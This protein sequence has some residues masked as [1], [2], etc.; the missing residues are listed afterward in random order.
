MDR[1]EV[2]KR[3][4]QVFELA[5]RQLKHLVTEYPDT[6]PSFTTHGKWTHQKEGW[7]NWCEGFLG[8]QLWLVYLYGGDPWF[9]Q[10]AEHYCRLVEPRQYD[11]TV[12]DLG[13]I[14][15]PTWKRWYDL[16]GDE[17]LNQVVIQAGQTLA[18]RF[19]EAGGYICSFE[20][21]HSTYIDI[22]SNIGLVFYAAQQT[23]DE[24]LWRIA[25][26]HCLTTR[27]YLVRGDGST[28]H[29]GIFD[30]QSGCFLRQQTRQGWRDDSSWVRGQCW[31]I[32]GFSEAFGYTQDMI[33]LDTAERLAEFYIHRTPEW[34]IP[35]NDWEEPAQ[36]FPCESSAAAIAAF[37]MWRLAKQTADAQRGEFYRRYALRIIDTLT[38][39]HFLAVVRPD[40]EGILMHGIY[41]LPQNTG[42]DESM[43]WGDYFLL[44]SLNSI[45]QEETG[46]PEPAKAY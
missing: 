8:G 44:E 37:G 30:P 11:T 20:G 45:A 13:F 39:S 29:E 12:H 19:Q 42:V 17:K 31:A 34:G 6:F 24:N 22:M 2:R 41:H 3:S 7:T 25:R 1:L 15:W 35:P 26:K 33:F 16:T 9:R 28:A 21:R 18:K 40:W 46:L 38:T 36:K 43:I 4:D 32:N 5:A 23:G 14:F 10:Q 27:R